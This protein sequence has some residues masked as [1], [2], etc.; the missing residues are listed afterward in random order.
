MHFGVTSYLNLYGE[1]GGV[2][3]FNVVNLQYC[4]LPKIKKATHDVHDSQTSNENVIKTNENQNLVYNERS[5]V[6]KTVSS[7]LKHNI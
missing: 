3:S 7:L 4:T 5:I 2:D 1:T 6:Q